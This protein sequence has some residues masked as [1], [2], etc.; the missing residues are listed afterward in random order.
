MR[1]W[2]GFEGLCMMMVE[3]PELV[4]EMARFWTDF[5]ALVLE[6][7][8]AELVPDELFL[9]EDMAYKH[10]SMI[11]PAMTRRFCTPSYDRWVPMARSAGVPVVTMDCDGHV[12]ELLEL[13]IASGINCCFPMEVAAGNDIVAC[14]RTHGRRMAYLAGVDKRAI[15]AGGETLAR[16]L[17]RVEPVLQS[18]GYIPGCDHGVPADVSW[19]NFV[20][21]AR[22]LAE[23]TGWL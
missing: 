19:A 14:R 5:V 21:Y 17:R 4:D 13:W 18:G 1:E 10:R 7:M 8:L 6:R 16:E 2:C 23:M 12:G 11:S 9:N 15:A 22:R 20:Q 3:R